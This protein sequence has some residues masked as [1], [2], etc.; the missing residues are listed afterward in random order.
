MQ[1]IVG[2]FLYGEKLAL[3]YTS[4][5][6]VTGPCVPESYKELQSIVIVEKKSYHIWLCGWC[7][8]RHQ[9]YDQS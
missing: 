1:G 8:T 9:A 7:H 2:V 4:Y 3:Y 5:K 6:R